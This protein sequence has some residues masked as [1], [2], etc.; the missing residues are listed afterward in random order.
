[1]L[2]LLLVSAVIVVVFLMIY[3]RGG[4]PPA[5]PLRARTVVAALAVAAVLGIWGGAQ[6][7][8]GETDRLPFLF[9][10]LLLPVYAVIQ[11]IVVRRPR[12][13]ALAAGAAGAL[14]LL[15]S[16]PL[17]YEEISLITAVALAAEGLLFG[18]LAAAIARARLRTSAGEA[19]S[20]EP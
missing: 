18:G 17:Y 12:D 20:P 2:F 7:W 8:A 19:I 11:G 5:R 16:L 13:C 3:T 4:A 15:A 14:F 9:M 1:M 10:G 6:H